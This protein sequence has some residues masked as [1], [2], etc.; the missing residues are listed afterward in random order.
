M[1]TLDKGR[2]VKVWHG[3]VL[4][5]RGGA[6][7]PTQRSV[8]VARVAENRVRVVGGDRGHALL[9]GV[10]RA[11]V[12]VARD[13]AVGDSEL[14]VDRRRRRGTRVPEGAVGIDIGHRAGKTAARW[15]LQREALAGLGARRAVGRPRHVV[16]NGAVGQQNLRTG[17]R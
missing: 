16:G 6:V 3:P 9:G 1:L 15:R 10:A 8:R 13:V 5:R 12:W 11:P 17:R 7:H 4:D 14:G 2:T